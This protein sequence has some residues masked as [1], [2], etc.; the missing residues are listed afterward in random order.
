MI[1]LPFLEAT[2]ISLLTDLDE[3]SHF[4]STD[5]FRNIKFSN[6]DLSTRSNEPI[7]S[8]MGFTKEN[9]TYKVSFRESI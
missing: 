5:S 6:Q 9:K 7:E 1:Q 8:L 4:N 2:L 3:C